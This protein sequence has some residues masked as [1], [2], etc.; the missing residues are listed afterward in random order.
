[1]TEHDDLGVR[2]RGVQIL[3]I[4]RPELVAMGDHDGEAVELD[5]GDGRQLPAQLPS[6]GV[7]VDRGYRRDG[8]ELVEDRRRSDVTGMEDVVDLPKDVE[9]RRPKLSVGIRD[10]AETHD[11][12]SARVAGPAPA[13]LDVDREV[14]EDPLHDEIHE[15]GDLGWSMIKTR[16]GGNDDGAGLGNGHEVAEV[17][18]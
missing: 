15:L 4:R 16:R 14:V 8:L 2:K 18:Q 17:H 11:R 6:V 1:V 9:H 5:G 12:A 3:R 13:D 7:A 10:D